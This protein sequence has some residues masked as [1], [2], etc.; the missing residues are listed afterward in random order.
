MRSIDTT[1]QSIQLTKDYNYNVGQLAGCVLEIMRDD[2]KLLLSPNIRNMVADLAQ[3][4]KTMHFV[5]NNAVCLDE[6][7]ILNGETYNREGIN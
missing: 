2:P 4:V 7:F 6:P 3:K 1:E 5:V